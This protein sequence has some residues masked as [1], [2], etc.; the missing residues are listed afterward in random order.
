MIYDNLTRCA[1]YPQNSLFE[2]AFAFLK[3]L[4]TG[5]PCGKTVLQGDDLFVGIDEYQTKKRETARPETHRT[6]IDIQVL[7]SGSEQIEVFSAA[8]LI[9]GDPYD[10]GRDLRF[11]DRPA[12][13]EAVLS[14]EP[15]KFAV[16]FPDD[17]HMPGLQNGTAAE[18]V[19]KAVAK[20]RILK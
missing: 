6:Y 8:N 1:L 19:K 16:F 11:Y 10:A 5:S 14:L 18:T 15:G 3:T 13:A 4:G 12:K 20:I 9:G 17:A 2:R 7:L